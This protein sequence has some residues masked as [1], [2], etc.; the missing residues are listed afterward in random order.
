M[1]WLTKKLASVAKYFYSPA[2]SRVALEAELAS[3]GLRVEDYA[4]DDDMVIGLD[5]IDVWPENW[6][7][8][9]LF[10]VMSTQ[11]RV[12]MNGREG[13]DY[14]V[15]GELWRRLKIP[16]ADRD[17]LFNDL[18]HMEIAALNQMSDNQAA[19]S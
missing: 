18:R 4:A 12:S 17:Y 15:L 10:S 13:L 14:N 16:V 7:S 3:F 19:A 2:R 11:W 1:G 8:Y 6:Q 9:V 5:G